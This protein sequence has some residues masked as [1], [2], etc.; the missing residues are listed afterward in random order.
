MIFHLLSFLCVRTCKISGIFNLELWHPIS[1]YLVSI[2]IKRTQHEND[3]ER[4]R[5][6]EMGI[7]NGNVILRFNVWEFSW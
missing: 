5:E 6:T 2:I 1:S 7:T 3:R 4:E